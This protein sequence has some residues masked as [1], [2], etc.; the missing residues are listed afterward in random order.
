MKD[1]KHSYEC[2]IMCLFLKRNCP[3]IIANYN[4]FMGGASEQDYY[5]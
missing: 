5:A 2:V 4:Q 1:L 3:D